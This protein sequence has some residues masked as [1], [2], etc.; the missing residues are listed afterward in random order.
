MDSA[1]ETAGGDGWAAI[2][3]KEEAARFVEKVG[4]LHRGLPQHGRSRSRRVDGGET[5]AD[6]VDILESNLQSPAIIPRG[7]YHKTLEFMIDV[8]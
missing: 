1:Q 2:Q 4:G 5:L 8:G 3:I 7:D 6:E